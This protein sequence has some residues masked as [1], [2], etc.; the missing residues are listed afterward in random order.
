LIEVTGELSTASPKISSRP[1]P[2]LELG[3]LV[4]RGHGAV[5]GGSKKQW[6]QSPSIPRSWRVNISIREIFDEPS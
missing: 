3:L 5:S 6:N 2:F 4:R 1:R